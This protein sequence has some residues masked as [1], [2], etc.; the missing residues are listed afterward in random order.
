MTEP[1]DF[2]LELRQVEGY[3]FD[4]DFGLDGAGPL[5]AD[6]APPLGAGS[7]PHASLLL[8]AAVGDCLSASLLYCLRKSHVEPGGLRTRVAGKYRRNERGRLRVGALAVVIDLQDV[9]EGKRLVRCAGLFEDYC[10]V[11]AS[12]REAIPVAVTVRLDGEVIHRSE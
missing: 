6:E 8:A 11:T 5:R 9:A 3:A 12:V 2:S 1:A 7:G 4:V 10:V